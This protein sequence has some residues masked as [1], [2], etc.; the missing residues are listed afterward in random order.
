MAGPS[1][2]LRRPRR[3]LLVCAAASAALAFVPGAWFALYPLRLA[4]TF[5]HE[6]G[7][8]LVTVLT[9]GWVQ[10][11]TIRPSGSGMTLSQGGLPGLI[12]M[13]GYLGATLYG[14]LCLLMSRRAGA[15][16]RALVFIGGTIGVLCALWVRD[17]FSL[18]VGG[19]LCAGLIW[20][21]ASLPRPAADFAAAFLGV[22]FCLNALIDI[23]TLLFLT[24]QTAA[25]NDAV[26]MAQAFGLTPWFWAILWAVAS[27]AILAAGLR[28]YWSP[29][30]TR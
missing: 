2:S 25:D 15:G 23:R 4:V 28:T 17:P 9:G 1:V 30:T 10:S 22:Q 29:P 3:L 12:Y 11:I 7:H 26:F 6:G 27:L 14:V 24:T 16:R 20:A 21:G 13:A 18:I 19:V 8:A 5:V